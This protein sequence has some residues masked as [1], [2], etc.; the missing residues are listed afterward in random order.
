MSTKTY[1]VLRRLG[2]FEERFEYLKLGGGVGLETFGHDRWMNQRFYTSPEWKQVRNH[3][4]LRDGGCDLGI[5]G[6]E[7]QRGL[8]IHHINPMDVA[9]IVHGE[10]W[11]LDP[12]YLITTTHMT[13]NAIHYGDRSLLPRVVLARQPGDT[14]LW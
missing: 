13:H 6:Y 4:I 1:S 11:I 3:V 2:S 12:E 9:D 8:L 10:E 5:P 7:I 14:K